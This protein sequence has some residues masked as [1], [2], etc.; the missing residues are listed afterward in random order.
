MPP[1]QRR[2]FTVNLFRRTSGRR[3]LAGW[4]KAQDRALQLLG[5]TWGATPLRRL[6]QTLCLA[7]YLYC[8][9]Y[10]AW[11]YA[12]VFTGSLFAEKEHLP[13]ELFLWIDPLT[14]LSSAIAARQWNPAMWGTLAILAAGII[15][16]RCFCGYLCPLGTMIGCLDWFVGLVRRFLPGTDGKG[17]SSRR[18]PWRHLRYYLLATVLAGSAMGV[19]LAGY[20]AAIP[21][22]TRGLLFSAGRLQLGLMRNWGQVHP[23][24][25]SFYLS[26]LLFLSIFVLGLLSPRFWC[27]YVCP[28]GAMFSI[29]NLLRLTGR[30]L[31]P[32][33][34]GCGK[35]QR[36]CPF[37]A[38][39]DDF[40]TRPLDCAFC[41][42]CGGVCPASEIQFALRW[43]TNPA[44]A[45][46]PPSAPG[47][48]I[49]RRAVLLSGMGGV[50]AACAIGD[51][52]QRPL[53]RPPGSVGEAD[54]Q[55]MCIRCGECFKVCPGPVLHPAGFESGL[56]NLWTPIVV[57]AL[58]G[59]HQDCNFCTQ[60][61][62]TG[63]IRPLSIEQKRRTVMGLAVID[64]KT[65]LPQRGERDCRLCYDE[66]AAA[67]YN[68]IEMR[69][70][71]LAVGETPPPGMSEA[72]LEE[73]ASI[74]SPFVNAAACIGCGLC[75]YRCHSALVKQRKL[76]ATTAIVV[77]PV[78][79]AT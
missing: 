38:I 25:A 13:V 51:A 59:C 49:S 68:A 22:L 37:D 75:E 8:F 45:R 10:V 39:N 56:A 16:P 74:N 71:K 77:K 17:G 79:T 6:I 70:I 33:C 52:D 40:S 36:A 61:C 31:R 3:K 58:A 9:F 72:D 11:P 66:C 28:S 65:C 46:V 4:H 47:P 62:P 57:P 27:R 55:Q 34:T 60:V 78:R 24:T 19:L 35:C 15:F 48:L 32:G 63:A 64:T 23:V 54:F 12:T 7:I 18:R 5:P 29:A 43:D 30:Q 44:P 14:G 67:G 69:P 2:T 21:V 1:M 42:T 53:L 20:V 26:L 41:Q 73:M 76:I 50:A